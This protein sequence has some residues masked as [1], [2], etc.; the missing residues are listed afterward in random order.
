MVDFP[1]AGK[2]KVFTQFQRA[3][4]VFTTDFVVTVAQG[5]SSL[6]DTQKT[7]EHSVH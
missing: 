7:M 3:G 6:D 4:K 5:T 1:E 2:Y